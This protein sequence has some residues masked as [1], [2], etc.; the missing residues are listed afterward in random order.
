MSSTEYEIGIFHTAAEC[1]KNGEN[2]GTLMTFE[3]D[4]S[5]IG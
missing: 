3:I 4:D 1:G 5:I 2:N